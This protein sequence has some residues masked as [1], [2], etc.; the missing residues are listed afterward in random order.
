M[1]Q[2]QPP[3]PEELILAM[4]REV[5]ARQAEQMGLR[6]KAEPPPAPAPPP[7]PTPP[8]P[9]VTTPVAKTE[10]SIAASPAEF[11]EAA[12]P[13]SAAELQ[14][15]A[16][17]NELA[18][19]P[20]LPS[21]LPRTLRL[22]VIGLV[23]L[24]ILI[25]IPVFNVALARALPDRQALIIRDG[26]LLKGSGPEV[27]VLESNH[28]R[29]ISSIDA[30]EHYGYRWDEVHVVD[31]SSL[32]EYPDGRPLHVLLK[33]NASPHIYR[34]ENDKK[35]WIKDIPTFEAEGHLW[36]DVRFVT[37]ERLREIPDGLPIPPDAGPPPQP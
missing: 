9:P 36:E 1:T 3:T 2:K 12:E 16:E 32:R 14:E 8:P 15:L 37:C 13:L 24:L 11:E 20:I 21:N 19:Q 25:N 23:A 4:L 27:Y 18:D 33:C 26:L 22:L 17:F 28:K 7:P 10:P 30:F 29:W 35:R 31:D 5:L 6:P 34:L